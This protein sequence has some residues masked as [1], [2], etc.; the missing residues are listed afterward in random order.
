MKEDRK[1]SEW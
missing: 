1:E